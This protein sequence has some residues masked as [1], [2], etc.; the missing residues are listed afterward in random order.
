MANTGYS[1]LEI[2]TQISRD[3]EI[4]VLREI[5]EN[6]SKTFFVVFGLFAW[7]SRGGYYSIRMKKD[8]QFS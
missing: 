7:V 3:F 1:K 5:K 8:T 6:L 2:I 4:I